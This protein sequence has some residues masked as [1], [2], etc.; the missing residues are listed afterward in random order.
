MGQWIPRPVLTAEAA[1]LS[2]P[3]DMRKNQDCSTG[4]IPMK[5][6]GK[7]EPQNLW[8]AR[9]V[10][11]CGNIIWLYGGYDLEE[12]LEVLLQEGEVEVVRTGYE[13]DK[14]AMSG[15]A[16]DCEGGIIELQTWF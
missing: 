5:L 6:T 9:R 15:Y 11:H 13:D 14:K 10:F 1:S 8:W 12:P 16:A 7:R 4:L 2:S 3:W